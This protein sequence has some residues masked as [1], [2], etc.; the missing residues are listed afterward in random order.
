MVNGLTESNVVSSALQGAG[1]NQDFADGAATVDLVLGGKAQVDNIGETATK[2]F[3]GTGGE[4]AASL[5]KINGRDDYYT[6]NFK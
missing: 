4:V 5:A 6:R 1:V 3:T 2:L